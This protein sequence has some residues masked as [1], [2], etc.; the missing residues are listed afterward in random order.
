MY[1]EKQ[2]DT[3]VVNKCERSVTGA[4][5]CNWNNDPS[6]GSFDKKGD[7]EEFIL[8]EKPT[9]GAQPSLIQ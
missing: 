8:I 3:E 2:D 9:E 4:S 6:I 7:S 1:R 5:K